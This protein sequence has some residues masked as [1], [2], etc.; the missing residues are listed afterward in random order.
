M[1]TLVV[2]AHPLEASYN[3]ALLEAVCGALDVSGVDPIVVKLAQGQEPDLI[4]ADF[5][6]MIAVCPTWWGGP[7]AVLLDWLQRTLAPYVDG[8][9]PAADSPFRTVRRLSVVT[10]HGSS[11]LVNRLQGEPGKQTWSRVILPFCHPDAEF[12]WISLYKIDRTT[13]EERVAF[14]DRVTT[15]FT[16]ARVSA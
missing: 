5:E 15:Q 14:L 2:Q 16:N 3:T 6:H 10:S 13:A 4:G 1:K 7:P 9:E 8:G 12:E 11:L